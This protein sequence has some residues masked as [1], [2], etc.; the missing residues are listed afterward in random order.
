M[1]TKKSRATLQEIVDAIALAGI[2]RC[3]LFVD[4]TSSPEQ[5]DRFGSQPLKLPKGVWVAC[6][7]T[8]HR[9]SIAHRRTEGLHSPPNRPVTFLE[10]AST[11]GGE[12][13]RGSVFLESLADALGGAADANGDQAIRLFETAEFINDAFA[14]RNLPAPRVHGLADADWQLTKLEESIAARY[15][16]PVEQRA[17]LTQSLLEQARRVLLT[18]RSIGGVERLLRRA[19]AYATTEQDRREIR[20]MQLTLQA[21]QGDVGGALT[22]AKNLDGPLLIVSRREMPLQF[23]PSIE[24][25][26]KFGEVVEVIE[27]SGEWFRVGSVYVVS[28]SG[29][30]LRLTRRSAP[31]AWFKATEA[32]S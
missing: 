5:L 29:D 13:E 12:A 19:A 1:E 20:L 8:G 24:G 15:Q 25:K 23:G 21:M 16:L 7:R 9:S 18:E 14:A 2:E 27:Q 17:A 22:Q 10:N 4:V 6:S 26:V 3:T 11:A 30:E 31:Q 28:T 32:V